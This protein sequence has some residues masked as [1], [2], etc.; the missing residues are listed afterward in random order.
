MG[1]GQRVRRLDCHAMPRNANPLAQR[2]AGAQHALYALTLGT[3]A[4]FAS[5]QNEIERRLGGA[6]E[7]RKTR[8]HKHIP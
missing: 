7:T 5:F 1:F 3:P 2:E 6:T 8:F 4:L